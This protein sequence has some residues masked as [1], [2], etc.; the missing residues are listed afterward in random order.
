MDDVSGN[1]TV[2]TAEDEVSPPTVVL[3]SADSPLVQSAHVEEAPRENL[4]QDTEDQL[5]ADNVPEDAAEAEPAN[6]KVKAALRETDAPQLEAALIPSGSPTDGVD[7][8]E[9]AN[10]KAEGGLLAAVE[11]APEPLMDAPEVSPA[12]DA[13]PLSVEHQAVESSSD[14]T[15]DI[16]AILPGVQSS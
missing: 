5:L 15:L 13:K 12:P 10:T 11:K 7:V 16:S 9:A 3:T 4:Q 6:G 1:A 8:L 14:A 2:M